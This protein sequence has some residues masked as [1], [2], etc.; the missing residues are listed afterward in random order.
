VSD[1]VY[2]R[3]PSKPSEVHVAALPLLAEP[4]RYVACQWDLRE[5]APQRAWW[6]ALFRRHFPT[7]LEEAIKEAVDRGVERDG[8]ATRAAAVQQ[9]FERYLDQLAAEPG[10]FGRLDIL[11]I[12]VERERVLRGAGIED[13]YRLPKT[14]ENELAMACLPS[15]LRELDGLPERERLWRITQGIFAGNIFDLGATATAD[16]FKEGTVDFHAVRQK[17][18]PRPWLIDDADCWLD[19][20]MSG[21]RHQRALLFVDN[22]GSDVILGMLPLARELAR[23]GT[24]VI[25]A[26]NATPT[27]N[28]VTYHELTQLVRRIAAEDAVVGDAVAAGRLE[29]ISSG[30]GYPLIELTRIA[31]ELVELVRRQPIDLLVLEGMGR[32]VESNLDARFTCDT[33]K[34]AMVKDRGVA[35][36]LGGKVYDL[37]LRFEPV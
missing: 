21:P 9:A 13:P 37:V 29:L 20:L 11:S 6:L 23:R 7:L 27:L 34:I 2:T 24:H 28:D 10:R 35:E 26:A 14:R 8:I 36:K 1:T 3:R 33:L 30:N 5:D 25:L 15:V 31:P 19:R 32:A 17:L 22:A 18:A 4:E 12:C 16:L